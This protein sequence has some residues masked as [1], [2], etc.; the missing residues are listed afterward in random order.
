MPK[1]EPPEP[2][3]I[4]YSR[5]ETVLKRAHAQGGTFKLISPS[6]VEGRAVIEVAAPESST[7]TRYAFPADDIE[8]VAELL[9]GINVEAADLKRRS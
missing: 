3:K 4:G 9:A 2:T 6:P 5:L 7:P 8:R 1:P